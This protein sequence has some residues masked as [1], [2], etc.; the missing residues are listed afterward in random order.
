[1]RGWRPE[2]DGNGQNRQ[3]TAGIRGRRPELQFEMRNKEEEQRKKSAP[4]SHEI[5]GG[6]LR[7]NELRVLKEKKP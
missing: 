4:V 2:I 7:Q 3:V 5:G 1:M 6:V